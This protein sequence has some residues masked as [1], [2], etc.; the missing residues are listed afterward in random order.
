MK[1]IFFIAVLFCTMFATRG[2]A[3]TRSQ[4]ESGIQTTN[5]YIAA[6]KWRE[7]FENLRNIESAIGSGNPELHYLVAKQ[8]Y[9]MYSRINKGAEAKN[10]LAAMEALALRSGDNATIENMLIIKAAYYNKTGG[11]RVARECYKTF[12][13]RR[14]KGKDDNGTEATFKSV[15]S[16]AKQQKNAVMAAVIQQ[17][18]TA[19]QDS[20]AGVRSANELKNTKQQLAAAQQEIDDK[21]GTITGQW[22]TIILLVVI[23]LVLAAALVFFILLKITNTRTI[24]KLRKSLEI[25]NNSNE[26]KSVFIRNISGQISPSLEQIAQGN[27]KAH[28]PALRQMLKHAEEY[29]ELESSREEKYETESVNVA[30]LCDEIKKSVSAEGISITSKASAM[31]FPVNKEAVTSVVKGIVHESSVMGGLE[32]VT[33][34]FKKRNPHTGQF[35]ITALGMKIAE[36]EREQ[37]FTPFAKIHDLTVTDGLVL[38]IS[39]LIAYKMGGQLFLDDSFAKGTRFVLEVHC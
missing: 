24:K 6:H 26:Q 2:N 22:A 7:A 3:I 30:T 15:I 9:I 11:Q 33:L 25:A 36:E 23:A 21:D 29:M 37:V 13:D 19:W 10:N 17:M 34:D 16:E 12:F 5:N 14:A 4:V 20:I 8:R 27:S 32:S 35:I 1:K 18:Y 39:A 28:V 38:P 31:Q